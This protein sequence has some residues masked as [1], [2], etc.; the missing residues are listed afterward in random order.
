MTPGN[1]PLSLY[2]GDTYRWRFS[3]WLDVAQ[4]QPADLTGVTATSQIRDKPGGTLVAAIA[5][6]VTLPNIIDAVLSAADS[7]KLPSSGAW[8]LQLL[9]ASGD[10]ATALAGTV[11]TVADV[12]TVVTPPTLVRA[13]R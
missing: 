8:D 10:V 1:L 4:T 2:K 3:L 9:Y 6:T 11:N 13:R 5:C 12:T 7:A